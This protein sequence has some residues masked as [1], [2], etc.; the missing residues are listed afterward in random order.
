MRFKLRITGPDFEREIA[1]PDTG[2]PMAIGRDPAADITLPDPKKLVSRRHLVVRGRED[3]LEVRVVSEVNGLDTSRGPLECGQR[4]ALAAGEHFLVGPYRCDVVAGD[5]GDRAG[6]GAV[7]VA[8]LFPTGSEGVPGWR[9]HR[10]D[11]AAG[12]IDPLL[13]PELWKAP[14]DP[15]PGGAD[16]LRGLGPASAPPPS[17]RGFC[18]DLL[19]PPGDARPRGRDAGPAPPAQKSAPRADPEIDRWLLG[20]ADRGNPRVAGPLDDL[21]A[22]GRRAPAQALSPDHVPGIHMPMT[23]GPAPM[24][25]VRPP[26]RKPRQEPASPPPPPSP[27]PPSA[28]EW[29]ALLGDF[30]EPVDPPV[31]GAARPVPPLPD[32]SPA[33]ADDAGGDDVFTDWSETGPKPFPAVPAPP[34][35]IQDAAPSGE[36]QAPDPRA[37][38]TGPWS[39]FLATLGLQD[40]ADADGEALARRAATMVRLLTE[41]L[42]D[43]LSA[44]AEMKRQMGAEDRTLLSNRDNNPLKLGLSPIELAN[45]LFREHAN[46]GYMPADRALRESLADL[47]VHEH[48]SFAAARAAVEGAL[49]EFEPELLRR[50]LAG[51]RRAW[52][53]AV[54]GAR[55][56]AAYV[57]WYD[58]QSQQ[59]ADWLEG[60]FQR[61]FMTTYQR[62]S[63]ILKAEPGKQ[64]RGQ[65]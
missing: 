48:A 32:A 34:A 43:L 28:D 53:G 40:E 8:R 17:A 38:G 58:Q 41:C 6:A 31:D 13:H 35:P 44:R 33:P 51:G 19:D 5:A 60:V 16:P 10:L 54:E 64:M 52:P 1:I 2:A 37:A 45:Y 56:W 20:R 14:V 24:A 46:A 12:S 11:A 15:A 30:G 9:E 49:R 27:G 61:H 47:R 29:D 55:T 62:E 3:G 23:L 65:A 39:T 18:G 22:Q 21:L 42:A 59:M 26:A 36:P 4:G 57:R 50:Q 63:E 7:A 25:D